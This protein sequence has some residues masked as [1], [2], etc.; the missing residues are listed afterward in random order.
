M[1]L[2][3][4]FQYSPNVQ[5]IIAQKETY[6]RWHMVKNINMLVLVESHGSAGL[7]AGT[8]WLYLC[9]LAEMTK[10]LLHPSYR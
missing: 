3:L 4:S 7:P 8:H 1:Y 10:K 5:N 2:L 6:M 9:L